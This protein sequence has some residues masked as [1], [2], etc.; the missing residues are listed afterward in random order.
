MM[1]TLKQQLDLLNSQKASATELT[2]EALQKAHA[3]QDKLNAFV[4]I[5]DSS[6][7]AAKSADERRA[8]GE[9]GL[10][11]GL[12]IALKDIFCTDGLKT[13]CG[14]KMLDNFVAPYDATVVSKLK[15]AGAVSIGKLNMDEF[16][17]GSS[18]ENSFYGPVK[19]PWNTQKVP[20]GSSGGSAA[21]VAAG[22]VSATL[23]T[24]TG[25]SIRQPASFCGITGLKPT[26]G[27]VSRYG[28]VAYASSLDQGGPM[29]RTAEDCALLLSAIA[30][31]DPR[32]S[33]SVNR[34]VDDYETALSQGV[35]GKVIGLPNQYFGEGLDEGVRKVVDDAIKALESLGAKVVEL[36]LP[37]QSLA[38]PA[39]YV[40]APAEASSNL[41][42]YDGVRFGYRAENPA[43]LNDLYCRSRSEAFG[44]EVQRRI[45]AGTYVLSE[46]YFDAYYRQAQRLRRMIYNEFATAFESVDMIV[47]PTTP[48]VA[49]DLGQNTKDPVAMYLNDIYTITANLAGIPG[50]SVPCGFS[51]GMPV[52]LQ[53]LGRPFE[54]G[55]LLAAGHAYQRATDWHTQQPEGL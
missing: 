26:Y 19:N 3:L 8:R 9:N 10:L 50:L 16:A 11:D 37:Q 1:M 28:M 47:G 5:D 23:G 53:I 31:H 40:I 22:I 41:S 34:P 39:Y 32:D 48:T 2:Q 55:T 38:L 27:R 25:G 6:L 13:S 21:A 52:G 36:D 42:R 4:T 15:S 44:E 45:I 43:D 49:F 35:A 46:G 14:S 24:D 12:P 54:E 29:A 18:N 17:M 33:T 51:D 30:G 20:G 7:E